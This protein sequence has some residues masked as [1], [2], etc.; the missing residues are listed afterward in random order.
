VFPLSLNIHYFFF[1]D[2]F[3]WW[4]DSITGLFV[5]LYTLYSGISTFRKSYAGFKKLNS[6]VDVSNLKRYVINNFD[7]Q[8]HNKLSIDG[9]GNFSARLWNNFSTP[10]RPDYSRI[11][12]ADNEVDNNNDE[13]VTF[14]A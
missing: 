1:I 12:M 14:V 7:R 13:T 3:L 2:K 4:D 11:P 10:T 6:E 8:G 5:A 9:G